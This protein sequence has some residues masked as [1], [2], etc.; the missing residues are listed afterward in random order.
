MSYVTECGAFGGKEAR[1]GFEAEEASRVESLSCHSM[2]GMTDS[3]ASEVK[4]VKRR[5]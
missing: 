3:L 4:N 5:I 1:P 2:V